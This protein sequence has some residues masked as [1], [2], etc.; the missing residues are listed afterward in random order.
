MT[1]CTPLTGI[2][3]R[4]RFYLSLVKLSFSRHNWGQQ[5]ER[6]SWEPELEKRRIRRTYWYCRVS[7]HK[8]TTF[9]S[10][11]FTVHTS[12]F[13]FL[14]VFVFYST[15]HRYKFS[16]PISSKAPPTHKY[17]HF[18]RTIYAAELSSTYPCCAIVPITGHMPPKFSGYMSVSRSFYAHIRLASVRWWFKHS[19]FIL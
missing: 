5:I 9:Q 2:R 15:S 13:L 14:P 12:L 19:A 8:S 16:T 17:F 7:W 1:T 6:R 18:L 10:S 11:I 3:I 4:R